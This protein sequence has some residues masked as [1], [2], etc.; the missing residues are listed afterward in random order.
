MIVWISIDNS[1]D[2]LSQ[3]V[4]AEYIKAVD[5]VI[6]THAIRT[7]ASMVHTQ[8]TSHLVSCHWC[9][10]LPSAENFLRNNLM[11]ELKKIA[12]T[13]KQDSIDWHET[14]TTYHIMGIRNEMGRD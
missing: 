7:R 9:I 2:Q 3:A 14:S 10:E 6:R 13:F 5:K 12:K 11:D 4:W 8:P 1:E